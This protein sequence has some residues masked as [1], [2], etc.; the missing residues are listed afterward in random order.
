MAS[1]TYSVLLPL[2]MVVVGQLAATARDI[3][4]ETIEPDDDVHLLDAPG[5]RWVAD[6]SLRLPAL[7]STRDHDDS[8]PQFGRLNQIHAYNSVLLGASHAFN[9]L[10]GNGRS[11]LLLGVLIVVFWAVVPL[12]EVDEYDDMMRTFD[13]TD[14]L[15]S[16][17]THVFTTLAL[18]V[19]GFAFHV[20]AGAHW[21]EQTAAFLAYVVAVVLSAN[22]YQVH[23]DREI[24]R[25]RE[26]GADESAAAESGRV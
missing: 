3:D 22:L 10:T 17:S 20:L 4:L 19:A 18:G 21:I 5:L 15:S 2:M 1:V 11:T 14:S 13:R 6:G 9:S 7:L 16:Y 25:L 26:K 8:V 24:A 23:L 12:I